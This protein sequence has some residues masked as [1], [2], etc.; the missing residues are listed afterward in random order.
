MRQELIAPGDL[1]TTHSNWRSAASR[2]AAW[3]R[4]RSSRDQLAG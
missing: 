3:W 2:S 1:P 4:S